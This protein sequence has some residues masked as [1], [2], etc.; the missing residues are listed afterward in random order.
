[1]NKIALH[2]KILIGMG[3]GILFGF[4][5]TLIPMG[6]QLISDYIKPFGT[7]FINLLKLIA[8]PLILASLIKGISD[9]K[10]ISK[11]SQMGGR[12]IIIYLIT[13]LTAVSIGLVLV[14]VIQPGKSISVET[15]NELVE[16]Y[17]TDTQAKQQAASKQKKN[18]S[19]TSFSR[20]SSV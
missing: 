13:T 17:A 16:A 14:N 5:F 18:W 10:D 11:L 8:I 1:M 4:L 12:T 7:I 15:R 6:G 20:C 9:L 19:T 3:L 2:W